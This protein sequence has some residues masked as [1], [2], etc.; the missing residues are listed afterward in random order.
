MPACYQAIGLSETIMKEYQ[1]ASS[2]MWINI[3]LFSNQKK[4]GFFS[5]KLK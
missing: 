3:F 4:E 1:I 5:E 2:E